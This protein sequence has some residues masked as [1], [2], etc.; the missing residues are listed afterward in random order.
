MNENIFLSA[1][2]GMQLKLTS[3]LFNLTQNTKFIFF[4]P[5]TIKLEL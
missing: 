4:K 3:L 2:R 5:T 1:G